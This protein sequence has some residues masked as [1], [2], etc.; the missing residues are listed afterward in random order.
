MLTEW[1]EEKPEFIQAIGTISNVTLIQL[2]CESPSHCYSLN[3]NL[4]GSET[5]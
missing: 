2:V 1:S 3:F 5:S 4:S